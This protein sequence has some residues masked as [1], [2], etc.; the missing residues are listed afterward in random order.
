M[1][2]PATDQSTDSG[3]LTQDQAVERLLT[4]ER[5]GSEPKA[6]RPD[7][8]LEDLPE[9]DED[10]APL[11]AEGMEDE[12]DL[13]ADS[14]DESE[15]FDDEVKKTTADPTVKFDDGTEVPLSE[16][17]RGFLRQQD[18]T[19]KTQEVAEVRRTV[20]AERQA[21]LAERQQ[22][23]ERLTPLIQQAISIIENPDMQRELAD[24][25]MND[26]GAYAVRVMEMQ[27][28][29]AQLQALQIE[30]QR[31]RQSA[32][33]EAMQRYQ[34]EAMQMAHES[35]RVL[36]ETIP[37]FKKDFDAEYAKLGKWVLEQ[38]VPVE[39][40]DN[41][42]DHR[43]VTLAWKAMQYDLA[44]RKP[45][46]T[47]DQLRRAPQPM[48]PGAA[49]PVGHAQSRALREAAEK[50]AK[51]GDFDDMVALQLLREKANRRR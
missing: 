26:P 3:M 23:S 39:A 45:Q 7:D 5:T 2:A 36:S 28:K 48:R 43:I 33:S 12:A 20:E 50:V 24:L 11:D 21:Y 18:Y 17:K 13:D 41:E 49:R 37:A 27:Q 8:L 32:E 35:R 9:E 42:R 16:V 31:L 34:Q 44:T 10:Q 4:R 1:S 46:K 25:R 38:G 29:Q 22:V 40:W 15:D 19:R 14:D 6:R 51:S 47:S 30:Q